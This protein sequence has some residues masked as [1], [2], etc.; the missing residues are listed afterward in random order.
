M[1]EFGPS[2]LERT[3]KNIVSYVQ[4]ASF[5]RLELVNVAILERAF[6]KG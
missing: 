3:M 4:R 1:F 6:G 5:V 2:F